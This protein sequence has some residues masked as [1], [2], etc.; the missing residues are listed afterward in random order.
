MSFLAHTIYEDSID[1]IIG[2]VHAYDL[3]SKPKEI[4][5]I[6]RPA[7]IVPETMFANKLLNIFIEQHKNVAIVV[8]EFGGTSGMLT[9]EDM[10]EEIFGEIE[11][12]F[13]TDENVEKTISQDEYIFSGRLKIDYLNEKYE[14]D[15]PK[16]DDYETLAGFI[17]HFHESIPIINEEIT[18][19]NFH[20]TILE[21]SDAKIDM[22]KLQMNKS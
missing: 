9:L 15:L 14:I 2:Y 22:V 21:A 3:F 11:D 18:I 12:E 17:I 13:D 4:L 20:F 8:D 10:I 19:D 5:K 1:N 7:V 6:L 16:T